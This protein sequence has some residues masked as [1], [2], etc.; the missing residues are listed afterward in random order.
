M[1]AL[2]P[3]WIR[4]SLKVPI[5]VRIGDSTGDIVSFGLVLTTQSALLPNRL[6]DPK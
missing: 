6:E 2:A 1:L 3:A 5:V 4:R